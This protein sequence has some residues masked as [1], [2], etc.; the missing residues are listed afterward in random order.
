MGHILVLLGAA[1]S[2]YNLFNPKP[3]GERWGR[4]SMERLERPLRRWRG[5]GY[6][7]GV[8]SGSSV[9]FFLQSCSTGWFV[10][11]KVDLIFM[12]VSLSLMT[13][14]QDAVLP[15]RKKWPSARW[16]G[17][18]SLW[19]RHLF[20]NG[21]NL[22]SLEQRRNIS[23]N[24]VLMWCQVLSLF[25]R[26]FLLSEVA[27]RP[28]ILCKYGCKNINIPR[29]CSC[30]MMSPESAQVAS[31]FKFH[32]SLH[33]TTLAPWTWP[34]PQTNVLCSSI[35]RLHTASLPGFL[36]KPPIS[37]QGI[38]LTLKVIQSYHLFQPMLS[39]LRKTEL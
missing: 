15:E 30:Q 29:S 4:G 6:W 24:W 10:S 9:T 27:A 38:S 33:W 31:C 36:S 20:E 25:C 7:K 34:T 8:R 21:Q 23:I 19:K 18:S 35:E 12:A 14:V 3:C 37:C 32:I 16:V 39:G 11:C 17:V 5:K 22:S 28:K 2:T 13:L 26:I 1:E